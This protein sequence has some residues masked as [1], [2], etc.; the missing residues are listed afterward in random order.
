MVIADI[1]LNKLSSERKN[2]IIMCTDFN[3]AHKDIDLVR[4]KKNYNNTMFTEKERLVIE[5]L[6]LLGFSDSYRILNS[7]A[8]N[9]SWWPYSFNARQRNLGWRIDYIFVSNFLKDKIVNVDLCNNILG[10]DHC[11]IIMEINWPYSRR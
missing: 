2:N 10:S 7:D 11:P 9:Y 4:P 5:K 3:I 6:L 1:I 8:G